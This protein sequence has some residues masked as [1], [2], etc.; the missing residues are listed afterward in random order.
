[1]KVDIF[2]CRKI[3]EQEKKCSKTYLAD[4]YFQKHNFNNF[5]EGLNFILV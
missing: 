3:N 2:Q 5:L 4:C 1:M